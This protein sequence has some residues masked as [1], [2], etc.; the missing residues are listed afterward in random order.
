VTF[1][2]GDIVNA[3]INDMSERDFDLKSTCEIKW[4]GVRERKRWLRSERDTPSYLLRFICF[5]HS[6]ES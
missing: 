1:V 2:G 3:L 4:M 6:A 5:C